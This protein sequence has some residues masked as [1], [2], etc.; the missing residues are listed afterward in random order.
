MKNYT[1]L[2]FSWIK[3]GLQY[4][5]VYDREKIASIFRGLKEGFEDDNEISKKILEKL[6]ETVVIF[7]NKD[8]N[9]TQDVP[10]IGLTLSKF[11]EYCDP[12]KEP[13]MIRRYHKIVW[14]IIDRLCTTEEEKKE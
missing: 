13:L 3:D 12:I 2:T 9:N 7:V 10:Q 1:T 6:P 8:A 4:K 5:R 11:D 14:S